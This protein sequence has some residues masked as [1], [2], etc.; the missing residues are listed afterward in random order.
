MLFQTF[1]EFLVMPNLSILDLLDFC[2]ANVVN[3]NGT[4]RMVAEEID[5]NS[6]QT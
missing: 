6:C 5:I 3:A 2:K 1:L 4:S